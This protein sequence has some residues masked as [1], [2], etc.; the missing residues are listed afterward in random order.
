[1]WEGDI[2]SEIKYFHW[3]PIPLHFPPPSLVRLQQIKWPFL[4]SLVCRAGSYQKSSW[5]LTITQLLPVGDVNWARE[6]QPRLWRQDKDQSAERPPPIASA[7]LTLI[8][9][10]WAAAVQRHWLGAHFP[11]TCDTATPCRHQMRHTGT[12]CPPYHSQSILNQIMTTT[13]SQI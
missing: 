12:S 5:R 1:M 8:S 4:C 7:Y 6:L 3:C 10:C 2:H 9:L 11:L 13:I